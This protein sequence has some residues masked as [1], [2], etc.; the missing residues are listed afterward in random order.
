M[1][2]RPKPETDGKKVSTRQRI[3]ETTQELLAQRPPGLIINKDI[4]DAAKVRQSLIYYYF[5]SQADLMRE[6]MLQLT[7]AYIARRK[8]GVDRSETFPRLPISDHELW[9]RAAA[10]FSADSGHAYSK[11]NWE[12]PVVQFEYNEILA[13]HP[14]TEPNAV[15]RHILREICFNFGWVVYKDT[16]AV[17]LN[18]D[19]E[20]LRAVERDILA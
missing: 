5:G 17:G 16:V 13:H 7:E 3:V 20:E 8:A 15:K 11:L 2:D 4:A 10:N 12:Y 19:A 6:A 14:E 9:W 1:S 18:M